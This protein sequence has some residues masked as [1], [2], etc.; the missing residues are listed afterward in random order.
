MTRRRATPYERYYTA[1]EIEDARLHEK[2]KALSITLV[3][4]AAVTAGI[5]YFIVEVAPW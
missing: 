5:I 2:W 1:E 4:S 3:V